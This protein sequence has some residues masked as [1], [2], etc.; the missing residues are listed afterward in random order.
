M[1]HF[2]GFSDFPSIANNVKT[3]NKFPYCRLIRHTISALI[4]IPKSQILK[5]YLSVFPRSPFSHY[6]TRQKNVLE[7]W[8]L[9]P[10][11]IPIYI[12]IFFLIP[13]TIAQLK[14]LS[15]T[16]PTAYILYFTKNTALPLK[17][18]LQQG[19]FEHLCRVHFIMF[20]VVAMHCRK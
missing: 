1:S 16:R 8:L 13:H 12:Y 18:K 7:L 3:A 9:F 4:Q 11:F 10:W 20:S 14:Q 5:A 6:M 19:H 2:T 15:S 17:T